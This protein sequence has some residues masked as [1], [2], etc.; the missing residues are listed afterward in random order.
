M[1]GRA[2][3]MSEYEMAVRIAIRSDRAPDDVRRA[4]YESLDRLVAE[5]ERMRKRIGELE[6]DLVAADQELDEQWDGLDTHADD[7]PDD[8]EC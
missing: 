1:G 6:E 8:E 7:E 5:N 4:G 3:L 2:V